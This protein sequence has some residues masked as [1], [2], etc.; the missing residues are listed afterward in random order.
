MIENVRPVSPET[1]KDVGFPQQLMGTFRAFM[2]LATQDIDKW[3]QGLKAC[4]KSPEL[5]MRVDDSAT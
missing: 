3:D 5:R 4:S 2:V 1:T